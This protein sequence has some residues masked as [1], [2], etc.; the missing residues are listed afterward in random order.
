MTY[1]ERDELLNTLGYR[2][3]CRVALCDWVEYWAVN[4]TAEI[5]DAKL[6]EQTDQF[7][8]VFLRNP[9][10]YVQKAS[11]LVI[12]D[13]TVRNVADISAV[14]DAVIKT[15]VNRVMANSIDVLISEEK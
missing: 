2:G 4:G 1:N 13:D 3:Q 6:R 7:I 12:S 8:R 9:E 10:Y 15:A 11:F 5:E 14:T